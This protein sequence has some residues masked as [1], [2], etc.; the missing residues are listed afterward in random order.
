M[1]GVGAVLRG[2]SSGDSPTVTV[3]STFCFLR[4]TCSTTLLPTL[5]SAVIYA[6]GLAAYRAGLFSIDRLSELM[7]LPF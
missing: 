4:K 5:L 1:G 7:G 3:T 2:P 6:A